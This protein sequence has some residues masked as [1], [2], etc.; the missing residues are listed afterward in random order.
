MVYL[1]GKCLHELQ[2]R[3][4]GDFFND[5]VMT[6]NVSKVVLEQNLERRVFDEIETFV[7]E[8]EKNK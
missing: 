8:I 4:S 5:F 6:W 2:A 7:N 1:F 3:A